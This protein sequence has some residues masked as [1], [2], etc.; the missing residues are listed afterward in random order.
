M[1]GMSQHGRSLTRTERLSKVQRLL[2]D[3]VPEHPMCRDELLELMQ[4]IENEV[5][6]IAQ[7]DGGEYIEGEED[8][9]GG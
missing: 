1:T 2:D 5:P 6:V 9:E 7:E 8:G 3:W 4:R